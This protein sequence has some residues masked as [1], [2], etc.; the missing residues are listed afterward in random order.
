MIPAGLKES[1]DA[2]DGRTAFADGAGV[3][4]SE[5]LAL[6]FFERGRTALAALVPLGD[7]GGVGAKLVDV[8]LDFLVETGEEG[9]DK[10]DDADTEND[11]E[12][13]ERTAQL[14]SAQGVH[15]L[16]Q[17]FAVS[18]SHRRPQFSERKASMG[19]SFAARMAGKM[20]KKRPTAVDKQRERKTATSGVSIGKEKMALTRKTTR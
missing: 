3:V 17:V 15:S 12:D 4:E 19:S 13:G 2:F 20:P 6:D 18:L 14:V 8:L 9:S 10:H 1:G 7:K 5:R 11:T 16:P